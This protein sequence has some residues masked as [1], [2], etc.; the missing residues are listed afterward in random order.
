MR[1]ATSA[2]V[3]PGVR[4]LCLLTLA[5]QP[6]CRLPHHRGL[7]RVDDDSTRHSLHD[8]SSRDSRF[9]YT[10]TDKPTTNHKPRHAA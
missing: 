8:V 2:L 3:R 7:R 9:V 10:I 5:G 4:T 6:K 1:L